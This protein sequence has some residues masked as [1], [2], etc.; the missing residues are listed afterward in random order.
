MKEK[1]H[2]NENNDNPPPP[3]QGHMFENIVLKREVISLVEV[4]WTLASSPSSATY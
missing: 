2:K 3:A 1:K 4:V